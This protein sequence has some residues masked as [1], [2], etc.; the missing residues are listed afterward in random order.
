M[1]IKTWQEA[2][3]H[4]RPLTACG[5]VGEAMQAEIDALRAELDAARLDALDK[6]IMVTG[7]RTEISRLSLQR[8]YISDVCD[9]YKAELAALK[10]QEP[11]GTVKQK[12]GY[13]DGHCFVLW[14]KDIKPGDLLFLAAGA[15]EP[16]VPQGWKLVPEVPTNEW[17]S[18]LAKMQSGSLEEVPFAEIHACIAE[19]LEAAP[20]RK[21]VLQKQDTAYNE[22]KSLAEFLFE[23]HYAQDEDYAS[24]KIVWGVCDNT[25]GII[26]QIDNMVC[27]LVLPAQERKPLTSAQL[28]AV[29]SAT[30]EP[31][32]G[33][34]GRWVV[35]ACRAIEAAHGIKAPS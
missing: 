28:K 24:G 22:A 29:I 12:C 26:S 11:C 23:K 4:D 14:T 2:L 27:G 31:E 33:C 20:E 6:S 25:A 3:G 8:D 34:V 17:I 7:L 18:N 15:Q 32:D 19:L 13:P 30:P 35:A 9:S 16:S 5:A 1:S 21:P 10:S